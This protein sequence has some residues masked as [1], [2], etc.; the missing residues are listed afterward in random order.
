M[1]SLDESGCHGV[2]VSIRRSVFSQDNNALIRA[3]FDSFVGKLIG[4]DIEGI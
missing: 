4:H 3:S 1:R 2:N